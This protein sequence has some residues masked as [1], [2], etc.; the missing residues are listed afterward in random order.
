L[1]VRM[2]C[3]LAACGLAFLL[4]RLQH[5][6]CPICDLSTAGRRGVPAAPSRADVTS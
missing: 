2:G 3:A 4:T 5:A 6:G 1:T